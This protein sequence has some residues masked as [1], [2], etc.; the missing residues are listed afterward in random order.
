MT[1]SASRP[2]GVGHRSLARRCSGLASYV[3]RPSATSR[4]ATHWTR[5]RSGPAGLAAAVYGASEGLRVVVIES[6]ERNR[7]L[8]HLRGLR[9]P[10]ILGDARVSSTLR[11]ANLAAAT[12]V[13][14]MTSNDQTNVETALTVRQTYAAAQAGGGPRVRIVLRLFDQGLADRIEATFDIHRARGVSALVAPHFLGAALDLPVVSTFYLGRQAYMVTRERMA[15]DQ[16]GVPE[17]GRIGRWISRMRRSG[18]AAAIVTLQTAGGRLYV[19]PMPEIF[20][21]LVAARLRP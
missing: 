13:A 9:V 7:F 19:G 15:N 21:S 1:R 8:A 16:A 10:L 5:I 11:R 18:Q 12:A 4:L 20:R 17:A 3:T 14:V 6:D 2:P